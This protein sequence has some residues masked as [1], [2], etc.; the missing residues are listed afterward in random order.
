MAARYQVTNLEAAHAA[1]KQAEEAHK[2]ACAVARARVA[3]LKQEGLD[4]HAK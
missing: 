3:T 2:A 4:L 1:A